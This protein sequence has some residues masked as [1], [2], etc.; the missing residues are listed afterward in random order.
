MCK[1]YKA[2]RKSDV[3]NGNCPKNNATMEKEIRRAIE[4]LDL[5]GDQ[6]AA[7]TPA[8]T[9]AQKLMPCTKSHSPLGGEY[10]PVGG[11]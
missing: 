7:A 8:T 6:Y 2:L 1:A 4:T 11:R 10:G 5:G 9:E 3:L